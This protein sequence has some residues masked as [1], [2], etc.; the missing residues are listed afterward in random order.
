MRRLASDSVV[1]CHFE[2][3]FDAYVEGDGERS[4]ETDRQYLRTNRMAV[5]P[6]KFTSKRW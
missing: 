4:C 6:D 3:G 5:R 2:R 1:E